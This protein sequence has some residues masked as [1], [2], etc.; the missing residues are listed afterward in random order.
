MEILVKSMGVENAKSASSPG[1]KD[2]AEVGDDTVGPNDD[3]NDA[4]VSTL[5]STASRELDK[6]GKPWRT[7]RFSE[8]PKVHMVQP[9]RKSTVCTHDDLLLHDKPL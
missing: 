2:Y 4:I 6:R 1:I 9:Y 7:I 8:V 5:Q 3:T